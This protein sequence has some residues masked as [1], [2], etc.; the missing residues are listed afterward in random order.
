MMGMRRFAV[1]LLALASCAA[2]PA[3]A[4]PADV[5]VYGAT[6]GGIC[7]AIAAA[8][9]GRTV[10]L[11]EPTP[12]I[13]GLATNGL[14]HTDFRTFEGITGLYLEF[15]RRVHDHYRRTYGP[16]SPEARDCFRG[17]Q[18][19]PSVNLKIF[20]E[21]LAEAPGL[22]VLRGWRLRAVEREGSRLRALT[23]TGPRVEAK[24]FIDGTYEGDLLARAGVPWR[25]GREGRTEYGESLAPEPGDGQLQAYNFRLIMTRDPARRVP[26][27]A[28]PAYRREDFV[29]VLPLLDSGKLKSVFCEQAGGV[30]KAQTPAPPRG[31]FDIN[32]VSRGL[33][34]LSLPGANLE[35]PD[36][37]EAAR[38]RIFAEHLRHN[39]GLLH[40][41]QN[42]AAV[43]VR[44]RDEAR[45]WGLVKDEFP[46]NGHLPMQLYVREARRMVGMRV[47]T[48][49]DVQ[50]SPGDARAVFHADSVAMGDYGP[51]CHG[52][53]H[54]G[55]RIGGRHTG[56]FYQACPPYQIPFGTIV[57]KEVP[58]LL[59]PVAASASH[60][61][62][63]ALRL[64]PVWGSMGQAAGTAAHLSIEL[65]RAV[66]EL[67]VPRIQSLLHAAGAATIYV[68]DVL[69]GHPRFAEV[70]ALGAAGK[71]HGR[72]KPPGTAGGR[73][74]KIAGQY[75]EAF[76]GHSAP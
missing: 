40:F 24:A 56:E 66:Q 10:I 20:E 46:E 65:G 34:R 8:R 9:L 3:G 35:W 4:L 68:S 5:A 62:F 16:D 31:V 64:E 12:R 44:I 76:P 2:P 37:D 19:E 60:V 45:D 48:E 55:P 51:N 53:G 15:T 67:P 42:D 63:C 11:L 21:M 29:E 26:V 17:T 7:A 61:G 32:D 59:V 28:P 43:P 57:P 18:A 1:L 75:F 41:L 14:S 49:K 47:F 74:A 38:A 71:L 54:E 6:P 30:Y 58:N 50:A 70:Q 23:G 13:G 73:G 27:T 25:V 22:R 39:T 72:E 52:T 36:G 69:P 33:V